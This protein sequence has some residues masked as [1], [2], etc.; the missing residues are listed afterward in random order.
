MKTTAVHQGNVATA[1]LRR[2]HRLPRRRRLPGDHGRSGARSNGAA[3]AAAVGARRSDVLVSAP[4]KA[5]R[6][7]A[8]LG[9]LGIL[10]TSTWGC[11]L[12]LGIEEQARRPEAARARDRRVDDARRRV[13]AEHGLRRA[14]CL[15][16]PRIAIRALADA[17]TGSA[18]IAGRACAAGSC[19]PV[20]KQCEGA[21]DYGLRTTSHSM[22]VAP[23]C[24]DPQDCVA[25]RWPF[26]FIGANN[27]VIATFVDDP[28]AD[29]ARSLTV[30]VEGVVTKLVVSG[31]R[32]WILSRVAD[33]PRTTLF[34]APLAYL[35]VPSNPTVRRLEAKAARFELPSAAA[36]AFAAPDGGLYLAI[37]SARQ[38]VPRRPTSPRRC[39]RPDASCLRTPTQAHPAT[40]RLRSPPAAGARRTQVVSSRSSGDGLVVHA[41]P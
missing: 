37:D 13:R 21:T 10:V 35:D 9:A 6:L 39:R 20:T 23:A 14:G 1:M 41:Y 25:A 22:T 24:T 38:P 26:V 30:G 36:T 3:S 34:T 27:G 17:G 2:R 18:E 32:L 5:R 15:L 19:N 7:R 33:R 8:A 11:N 28:I 4:S 40:R 16:P 29:A 12:L 31:S